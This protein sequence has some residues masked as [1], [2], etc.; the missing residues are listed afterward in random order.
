VGCYGGQDRF[1]SR[2]GLG[3]ILDKE[4]TRNLSS[5][6]SV[7]GRICRARRYIHSTEAGVLIRKLSQLTPL[8]SAKRANPRY[9]IMLCGISC[10]LAGC[11]H[12]PIMDSE[13]AEAKPNLSQLYLCRLSLAKPAKINFL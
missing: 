2:L 5:V 10:E 11:V 9:F 4:A 12:R 3:G 8:R 6:F 1:V 7:L 13:S